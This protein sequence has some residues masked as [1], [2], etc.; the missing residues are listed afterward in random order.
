MRPRRSTSSEALRVALALTLA[1]PSLLVADER[2]AAAQACCIAPGAA[3]AARLAPYE[4]WLVGVDARAQS[5]VGTFDAAGR[6]RGQPAGARELGL[7][8]SVFSTVRVLSRGQ[9]TLTV[10]FVQTLRSAGGMSAAG[11]GVG[12]VRFAARWDLVHADDARPAPGLALVGGVIA[13]T[14]RPPEQASDALAAGAT[15]TGAVQGWGGIALEQAWGP[16]L[17]L[18]TATVT[19]RAEREVGPTRAWLPPRVSTG[20]LGAY[21]WTSGIAL[22][23][24]ATYALVGRAVVDGAAVDGS[25]RRS[26]TT[27]IALQLP[28]GEIG[29]IVT[30]VFVTPPLPAVNAGEAATVGVSI[31][32]IRP[33]S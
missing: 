6:F 8:Q 11:G 18:A 4:T 3:G 33:W 2:S 12:D 9:L 7:E 14:G 13:P 17:A 15:G 27:T 30:S 16:G 29:R 28:A 5:P 10:P 23:A 20:L 21:S 24:G 32:L 31:A 1:V 22:A 19:V 26:L 25:A